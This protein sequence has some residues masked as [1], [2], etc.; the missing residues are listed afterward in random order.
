MHLPLHLRRS[1]SSR[2]V[3]RVRVPFEIMPSSGRS[4]ASP[5]ATPTYRL[6]STASAWFPRQKVASTVRRPASSKT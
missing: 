4:D 3:V 5:S 2:T 6:N 1:I